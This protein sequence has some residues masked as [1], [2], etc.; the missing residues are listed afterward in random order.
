MDC[1]HAPSQAISRIKVTY[2][3]MSHRRRQSGVGRMRRTGVVERGCFSS[4]PWTLFCA[5][6]TVIL[7]CIHTLSSNQHSDGSIS[8]QSTKWDWGCG[9]DIKEED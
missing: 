2:F 9:P 5:N 7:S 8:P 6:L 3:L 1:K 4:A